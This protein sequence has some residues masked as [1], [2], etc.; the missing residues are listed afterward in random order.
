MTS[1]YE[2]ATGGK[3]G[4]TKKAG[5]TLV[6]TASKDG[7]DLIV[8]TLS[9]SSDW[10]DHMN[11]FDKGFERFKQ[12]NVVGQGALA[13]ITEKK[14]ANHVYTKNSFAVPLTEQE[15]KNVVLKVELDK[16]AKLKDGV[17]V[18]KTEI[19]VGNEKVGERNL[20]YSKRKLVATTGSVLE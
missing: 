11:L 1:Y 18:G 3:T 17:K 7:L 2:F 16:S 9:A 14:Y 4:F 10:D 13:E 12:T 5:R 15:R 8:V 6:T 19:Y 20:F